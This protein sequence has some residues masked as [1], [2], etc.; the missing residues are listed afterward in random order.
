MAYLVAMTAGGGLPLF[1]RARD[2]S[3][4]L[5]FSVIASLNGVQMYT[6]DRGGSLKS[7]TA[8]GKRIVWR[9]FHDS[10]A[11]ILIDVDDTI[12]AELYFMN[13]LDLCFDALVL[14][15]GIGKLSNIRNADRLKKELRRVYSLLDRFCSF[16]ESHSLIGHVTGLVDSVVGPKSALLQSYLDKFADSLDT[17]YSCVTVGGKVCAATDKW[18]QLSQKE[19]ILLSYL[20]D[21]THPETSADIPVFLP[22]SS[23]KSSHRLLILQLKED[24]FVCALCG[25]EQSIEQITENM[26]QHWDPASECLDAIAQYKHR[27]IPGSVQLDPGIVAFIY[28]C[29]DIGRCVSSFQM[30]D[31]TRSRLSRERRQMVLL[32]Y[33]Q[34][35]Q[36]EFMSTN[37]GGSIGGDFALVHPPFESYLC[38]TDYKSYSL[39]HEKRQLFLLFSHT[40]PTFALRDVSHQTLRIL[41]KAI[42]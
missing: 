27:G 20:I 31:R 13:V 4:S 22:A 5:P 32:Q 39:L 24:I 34:T 25:P 17:N 10:L 37:E 29:M 14:Y 23:P 3:N 40:V 11:M 36:R 21:S 26:P 41:E 42:S 30:D 9:T 18:W 33:Y 8:G 7:A 19:G 6:G 28:L 15:L 2:G 16:H 35:T 12:G 1:V 38:A